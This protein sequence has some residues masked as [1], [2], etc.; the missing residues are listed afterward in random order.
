MKTKTDKTTITV[1]RHEAYDKKTGDLT[2]E[3]IERCRDLGKRIRQERSHSNIVGLVSEAPRA[4]QTFK[5]L[6]R[7]VQIGTIEEAYGQENALSFL[8][9][10]DF[11]EAYLDYI[12][13]NMYVSPVLNE[14]D[15]KSSPE[16]SERKK[17]A[18][19]FNEQLNFLLQNDDPTGRIRPMSFYGNGISTLIWEALA[20]DNLIGLNHYRKGL[21]SIRGKHVEIDT[22]EP[23]VSASLVQLIGPDCDDVRMFGGGFQPG[24]GFMVELEFEH[25]GGLPRGDVV[26]RGE[27]LNLDYHL[28][29]DNSVSYYQEK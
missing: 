27:K 9:E 10:R 17:Q 25:K 3:A 28:L 19:G 2:P 23:L 15:W 22:H 8:G 12:L 16:Y 11:L 6:V 18:G 26:F 7:G 1:R 21:T 14:P 5:E 20:G 29:L 4:Q 24:E 13:G